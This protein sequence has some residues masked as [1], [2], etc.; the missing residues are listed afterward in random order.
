MRGLPQ[1]PIGWHCYE[2]NNSSYSIIVNRKLHK[3][4]WKVQVAVSSFISVSIYKQ[5]SN[6]GESRCA[7]LQMIS[8]RKYIKKRSIW[9]S[10]TVAKGVGREMN[11]VKRIIHINKA[12]ED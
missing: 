4:Q 10:M 8:H 6:S 3:R 12:L 9:S 7:P 1:C 11:E 2:P 5:R